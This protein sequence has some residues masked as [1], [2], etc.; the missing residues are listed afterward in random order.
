M[1]VGGEVAV[2]K[3][4]D[5]TFLVQVV[6]AGFLTKQQGNNST[7]PFNNKVKIDLLQMQNIPR[8]K[9]GNMIFSFFYDFFPQ[10]VFRVRD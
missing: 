4:S 8:G 1:G 10:Y 3:R 2:T 7:K 9:M 5:L 6:F